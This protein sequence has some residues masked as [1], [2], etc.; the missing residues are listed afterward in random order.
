MSCES[1]FRNASTITIGR[2][3]F[4]EW[5]RTKKEL[6]VRHF[7]FSE[8]KKIKKFVTKILGKG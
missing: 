8:S 6:A 2:D 5:N 4:L 3:N 7:E 1:R